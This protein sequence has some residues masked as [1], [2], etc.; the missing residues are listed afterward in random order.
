MTCARYNRHKSWGFELPDRD[1]ASD[2]HDGEPLAFGR[3]RESESRESP[4]SAARVAA[5]PDNLPP[6]KGTGH[7]ARESSNNLPPVKVVGLEV[8]G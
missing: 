6:V 5:S 7:L 1:H 8:G 4:R 3:K 2:I